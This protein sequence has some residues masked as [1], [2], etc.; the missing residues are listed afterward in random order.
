M[1]IIFYDITSVNSDKNVSSEFPY[2]VKYFIN[3]FFYFVFIYLFNS[4]FFIEVA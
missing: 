3:K 2:I 1:L 4:Y